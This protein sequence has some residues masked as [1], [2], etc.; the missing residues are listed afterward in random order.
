MNKFTK[1]QIVD[2]VKK[3]LSLSNGTNFEKEAVTAMNMARDLLAK[4]N[5]TIED[6]SVK[7][8]AEENPIK[9]MSYG[10][11]GAWQGSLAVVIADY[12]SCGAF[13]IKGGG[14]MFIGMPYEIDICLYTYEIVYKQIEKMMKKKRRELRKEREETGRSRVDRRDSSYYTRGYAKGII[15]YLIQSLKSRKEYESSMSLVVVRNKKID[16][17]MNSLTRLNKVSRPASVRGYYD[18]FKD[19]ST[20]TIN[21]AVNGKDNNKRIKGR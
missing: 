4:Y 11:D 6:I 10:A 14:L 1:Q 17:F 2:K 12:C 9:A 18:G 21:K 19:G 3:L 16:D 20:I 7:T 5:M 13:H 15:D 8:A